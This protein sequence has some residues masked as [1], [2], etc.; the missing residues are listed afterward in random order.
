[1]AVLTW[2]RCSSSQGRSAA[3]ASQGARAELGR[4]WNMSEKVWFDVAE[5]I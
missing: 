3:R 1:M 4:M 5:L 2:G